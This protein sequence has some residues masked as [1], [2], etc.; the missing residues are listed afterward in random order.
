MP[1]MP[2]I[3]GRGKKIAY[4]ILG[5]P[6]NVAYKPNKAERSI[7]NRLIFEETFRVR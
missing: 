4:K 5:V 7:N 6:V 1:S 3:K 2:R